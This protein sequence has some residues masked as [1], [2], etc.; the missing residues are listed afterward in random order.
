MYGQ[1]TKRAM[2]LAVTGAAAFLVQTAAHAGDS[3][4]FVPGLPSSQV[5][6]YLSWP[7]GAHGLGAST[8]GLRYDRASAVRVESTAPFPMALRHRSLVQLEFSRAAAPRVSFDSRVTWDL[9]R[10]HLGPTSLVNAAWPLPVGGMT[11]ASSTPQLP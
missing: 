8:F 10:G 4:G 1:F 6:V 11:A 2:A 3:A 5:M 9:G 7:V